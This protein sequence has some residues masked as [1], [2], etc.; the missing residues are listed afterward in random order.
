MS[1]EFITALELDMPRV[2]ETIGMTDKTRGMNDLVRIVLTKREVRL[3]DLYRMLFSKMSAKEFDEALNS[4][5]MAGYI[6]L[7]DG[8]SGRIVKALVDLPKSSDH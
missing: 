1:S 6:R 2:F 3:T 5:V 7:E 4:S 8:S